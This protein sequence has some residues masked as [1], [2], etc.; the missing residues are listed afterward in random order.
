MFS[1]FHVIPIDTYIPYSCGHVHVGYDV[2]RY[3]RSKLGTRRV[4]N[5][6]VL[7]VIDGRRTEM[8]TQ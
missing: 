1:Q 5:K 7:R 8:R 3:L 2:G 4:I 6:G